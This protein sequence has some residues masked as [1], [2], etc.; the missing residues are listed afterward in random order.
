[1]SDILMIVTGATSLTLSDGTEHPTGFWAEELVVAHRELRAAGHA[2]TI[3]T[4]GGVTPTVDAGS[5]SEA[6]AGGAEKAAELRGYLD[7]IAPELAASVP[8]DTIDV[9]A[10][11]AVVLPGGHGPMT[12]LA[13][14]ATTGRLLTEAN[15][16]G[17]IIAPFCH[18][19][20]A[21]LSAVGA[22]GDFAFAGRRLTVFTDHEELT[23]GTGE[24]T[25]WF[26][27]TRLREAGAVVETGA[28]WSSH[29]VVDGNLISGQNPQSSGAVAAAVIEALSAR[30]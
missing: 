3:A 11:D 21:L 28:D 26:V 10:F 16:A 14:D 30:A 15:A 6:G 7:E 17:T 22:D 19:P 2:I 9:S 25:P 12:D 13:F 23:G 5:I 20:A 1:M 8:L 24:K 18:G 29:V 4:P 27:E